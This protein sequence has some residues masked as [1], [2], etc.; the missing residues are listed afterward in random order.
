MLLTSKPWTEDHHQ[1][2]QGRGRHCRSGPQRRSRSPAVFPMGLLLRYVCASMT[3]D[4]HVPANGR[5]LV[6]MVNGDVCDV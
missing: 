3:V 2:R 4:E 5:T 1:R 6:A